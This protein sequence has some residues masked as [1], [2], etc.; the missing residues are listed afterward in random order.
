MPLLGHKALKSLTQLIY[1]DKRVRGLLWKFVLVIKVITQMVFAVLTCLLYVLG[2]THF[3]I[4]YSVR[5]IVILY[6]VPEIHVRVTNIVR[7]Q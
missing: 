3:P 4:P 2:W 1:H 7:F 6:L 5:N